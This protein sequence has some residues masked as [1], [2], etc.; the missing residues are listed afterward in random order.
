MT[1]LDAVNLTTSDHTAASSRQPDGETVARL[2]RGGVPGPLELTSF[3]DATAGS[4]LPPAERLRRLAVALESEFTSTAADEWAR[5]DAIYA[6]AAAEDPGALAT[7]HSWGLAASLFADLVDEPQRE[8]VLARGQWALGC[9]LAIGPGDGGCLHTLGLLTY[10]QAGA[11]VGQALAWFEQAVARLEG[12]A[13]PELPMAQLYVAHCRQDQG[14]WAGALAAYEVID[15]A[16]LRCHWPAW[17]AH[18]LVALVARCQ[19]ELGEHALARAGFEAVLRL[20]EGATCVEAT[21]G[22]AALDEL[23]GL[24]LL[25]EVLDGSPLAELAPRLVA[26]QQRLAR[27]VAR[28]DAL[29]P[30]SSGPAGA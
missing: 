13:A 6:R 23:D 26:C 16:A 20:Y 29:V 1:D 12:S 5:L 21:A 27:A 15:R 28:G 7:F 19:L 11:P 22:P 10:Q 24:D 18:R 2:A 14:D 9:A 3:L 25:D 4:P 30:A 17:R 8:A